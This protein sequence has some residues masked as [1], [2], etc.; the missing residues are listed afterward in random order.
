MIFFGKKHSV[1]SPSAAFAGKNG[2]GFTLVEVLIATLVL[3]IVISATSSILTANLI[4]AVAI[5]NNYIASGLTQEGVEVVRNIRDTGWFSG[6][7]FNNSIPDGTYRAQWNSASFIPFGLNPALLKDN[8]T[9]I[10]SYDSGG[11]TIFSRTMNIIT[12]TSNVEK[13]ITV[14]VSWNERGMAKSISAE[15][16]LFNWR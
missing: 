16:H 5:K 10:Y 2:A 4:S 11:A 3:G 15:D 1:G 14:T 13:K 6:A 12:V 7:S 8:S 9:G